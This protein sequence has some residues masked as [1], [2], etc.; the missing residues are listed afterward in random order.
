MSP[1]DCNSR[2]DFV[3]DVSILP[4]RIAGL[5]F[6]I[7]ESLTRDLVFKAR[8]KKHTRHSLTHSGYSYVHSC[9]YAAHRTK[10]IYINALFV[11]L[12]HSLKTVLAGHSGA[13]LQ[14]PCSVGSGNQG[15]PRLHS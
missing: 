2:C 8:R 11:I 10:M 1:S 5:S 7:T 6:M 12:L 14:S 13:H 15:H 4:Q 9:G 3:I